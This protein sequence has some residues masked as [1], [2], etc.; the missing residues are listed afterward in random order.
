[1]LEGPPA[2]HPGEAEA[3]GPVTEALAAAGILGT[4][5]LDPASGLVTARW[6]P[7][8]AE[9]PA[10]TLGAFLGLLRPDD[11]DAAAAAFAA[12]SRDGAGFALPCR[13]DLPGLPAG[14]A[15]LRGGWR[16]AAAG[17][18]ARIAGALVAMP[19][20]AD[21]PAADWPDAIYQHASVGIAE[22]DPATGR[23][24]RMNDA[25]CRLTG[26][27][28]RELT[29]QL[30]LYDLTH[31]D[32]LG[33]ERRLRERLMA[34]EIASFTVEKRFRRGDGSHAWAEVSVSLAR[35][36]AVL[37]EVRIVQG[38][39]GRKEAEA[40][41][42]ESE[43]R[44]RAL[45]ESVPIGLVAIDLGTLGFVSANGR[46]AAQLGYSPEELTALTV[47]DIDVAQTRDELLARAREVAD[48]PPGTQ[49]QL[50]RQQ[51]CRDGSRRD[52]LISNVR[53]D[54]GGRKLV[55][56]AWLDVTEQRA[57]TAALRES[58]A[59]L[60]A[61][62]ESA[63][64]GIAEL[65]PASRRF[66]HVNETYAR[67]AGRS[68]ASCTAGLTLSDITPPADLAAEE[69]E[70]Q[71][72]LR[73]ELD[74]YRREKRFIR[75]DGSIGW[76]EVSISL[77]RDPLG[78][79]RREIRVMQDI[80]ARHLAEAAL[81]ES[82]ERL[83]LALAAGQV[84]TFDFDLRTREVSWD[85]RTRAMWGIAPD[86][87][88]T[89]ETFWAGV[90]PDDRERVRRV[91][92][93]ARAD[94]HAGTHEVE[95]RVVS[96]ADG[97]ERH[98]AARWKLTM[99]DGQPVRVTGTRVDVTEQ[100]RA[101]EVLARSNAEL[102]RLVE[103]RTAEL[104]RSVSERHA[105]QERIRR[106]ERLDALGQL[107]GGVAHDFNNLLTAVLGGAE[108]ILDAVPAGHPLREPAETILAGAERGAELT[109]R[110][111][112]FAREQPLKPR[113]VDVAAALSGMRGLLRRVAGDGVR[114]RLMMPEPAAPPLIARTDPVQLETSVLNLVANARDAMPGGGPVTISAELRR[115][116][117]EAGG[118]APGAYVAVAVADRGSGMPPDVL[119]RAMEPF[120]TTK[121]VGRGTGLGLSMVYGFAQQSGGTAEIESVPGEGTTVRLLLPAAQAEAL[122]EGAEPPAVQSGHGERILVVEDDALVRA[123][124]G[125]QLGNLGYRPDLAADA[126]SA[127]ARL[128]AGPR[129]DLLLTDAV[130]PGGISGMQL[131]TEAAALQPG[132][133]VILTTGHGGAAEGAWRVLRKP[134]RRSELAAA[135]RAALSR[136]GPGASDGDG[137]G[138]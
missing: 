94:G 77:V 42:Q 31:P 113:D 80:T 30:K 56:G 8:A 24:V 127:L 41:L 39:S 11:R 7:P 103:E 15:I 12:A 20:P 125:M 58:E 89:E 38:I 112:A 16:Q 21:A 137:P 14:H 1:M 75:P 123:Q 71:A 122:P 9:G 54:V 92:A 65:D 90:H 43:A 26:F 37:R 57:A 68:V 101:A 133:A 18:P 35:R 51:R 55:Y 47:A 120:F 82:E 10:L 25:Y 66:L 98:V 40:A 109:R 53:V 115:V 49:F 59:R 36:G 99:V 114:L 86:A 6:L 5:E 95:H 110:L 108:E 81:R 72:L 69:P 97:T 19:A 118:L 138:A 126:A 22:L 50:E 105:L 107:T 60:R 135:L 3:F 27:S 64:V 61:T 52:V 134:Y 106:T 33:R 45:F 13:P 63:A 124:L 117:E 85:E 44:F 102:E 111:L 136:G 121:E 132:I 91:F 62:Y 2:T 34:G 67:V 130:M 76:A 96:L 100:R 84:G 74:S 46:A 78:Q 73:G 87:P 32:D 104:R 88:V 28:R 93:A 29:E 70:R 79:P 83:R 131:A 48:A 17:R 128:R 119:A 116:G 23:L 4:F 129:F